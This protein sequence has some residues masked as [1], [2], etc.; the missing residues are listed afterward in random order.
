M[1]ALVQLSFRCYST[2]FKFIHSVQFN[3]FHTPDI[4]HDAWRQLNIHVI[5]LGIYSVVIQPDDTEPG[6]PPLGSY[7]LHQFYGFL[8]F[9]YQLRAGT[10]GAV[11]A[12]F[13]NAC[14]VTCPAYFL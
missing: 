7:G 11:P 1:P 12:V 10:V 4:I 5:R 2:V 13:V 8:A 6:A 14:I 9:Q 3:N